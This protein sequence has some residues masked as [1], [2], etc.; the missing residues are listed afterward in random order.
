MTFRRQRTQNCLI[1][2]PSLSVAPKPCSIVDQG[3]QCQSQAHCEMSCAVASG[4]S[5]LSSAWVPLAPLAASSAVSGGMYAAG[6]LSAGAAILAGRP[7][8][9][10]AVAL[11]APSTA[12]LPAWRAPASGF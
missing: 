4:V 9:T 10:S 6:S 3:F 8:S 11:A 12:G 5:A 1:A 2:G 7:P